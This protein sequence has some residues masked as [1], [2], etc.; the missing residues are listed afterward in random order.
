MRRGQFGGGGT[1]KST[2]SRPPW[3][4]PPSPSPKH[5][6]APHIRALRKRR[7][8][9]KSVLK[10][11]PFAC[12]LHVTHLLPPPPTFPGEFLQPDAFV[13]H[14]YNLV[15]T[16]CSSSDP[17]ICIQNSM[18]LPGGML[19]RSLFS[20]RSE[21]FNLHSS[22][23]PHL[24][25]QSYSHH[26]PLPP[27]FEHELWLLTS[28]PISFGWSTIKGD[29]HDKLCDCQRSLGCC[30]WQNSCHGRDSEVNGIDTTNPCQML[31]KAK[32]DARLTYRYHPLS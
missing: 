3:T 30:V 29:D 23:S 16:G 4:T 31:V 20:R 21:R 17:R 13:W 32:I 26:H 8:Y 22:P 9:C 24:L 27:F 18:V 5:R 28:G 25:E 15:L 10:R 11:A 2:S 14:A 7:A 1:T 12:D 19:S 6:Q